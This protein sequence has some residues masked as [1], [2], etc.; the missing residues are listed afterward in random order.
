MGNYKTKRKA[1]SQSRSTL[2]IIIILII[3]VIA[4][5]T[6]YGK[7]EENTTNTVQNNIALTSTITQDISLE[8]IPKYTDSPYIAINNNIPFFEDN[9]LT[10]TS[11]E[12]YSQLDSLGRCGVCVAN[13]GQDLMPTESRGD[14]GSVKPTGWQTIKYDIVEGKYLYNRCHL[15]GYQL[16]AEN[17]NKQNLITGTRYLNVTGMLPFENM[18]A[19]YVKET[20]NHVYYRVTPIFDGDNLVASG[21]LMEAKSVED[22][23]EGVLYNVYCYN[24][25]PGIT[26]NY[27][28]GE[29]QLAE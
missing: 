3:A 17:A 27:A 24:V 8:N 1:K 28:T 6:G 26:I 2:S 4:I 11:F 20:G 18:V 5:A 23:G 25:Q 29:S 7:P 15:I 10:T 21:V 12:T 16:T 14:I 22:N 13:V 19:D 9:E